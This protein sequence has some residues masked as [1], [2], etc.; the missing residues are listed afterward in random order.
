MLNNLLFLGGRRM[1]FWVKKIEYEL[2]GIFDIVIDSP[3]S[4]DKYGTMATLGFHWKCLVDNQYFLRMVSFFAA[5]WTVI[6]RPDFQRAIS[7]S[8]QWRHYERDGVSNH[9]VSIRFGDYALFP[10]QPPGSLVRWGL[11]WPK[12]NSVIQGKHFHEQWHLIP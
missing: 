3:A 6:I 8:P 10:P 1:I 12:F 5:I 2:K 11:E 7:R 4:D 9:R